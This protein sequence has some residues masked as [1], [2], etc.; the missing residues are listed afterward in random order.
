M[1]KGQNAVLKHTNPEE[2]P[3]KSSRA[4]GSFPN[5][6]QPSRHP[7]DSLC[8]LSTAINRTFKNLRKV[9]AVFQRLRRNPPLYPPLHM[10]I[11]PGAVLSSMYSR[12]KALHLHNIYR[13]CQDIALAIPHSYSYHSPLLP[14]SCKDRVYITFSFY[15]T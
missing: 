13:C 6:L 11:S 12:Y 1:R 14:L 7:M 15:T 9:C 2:V 3:S 10:P 8:F 5:Q 4:L